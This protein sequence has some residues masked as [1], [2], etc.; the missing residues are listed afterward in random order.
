MMIATLLLISTAAKALALKGVATMV[1]AQS[2]AS[3]GGALPP[4][5][6]LGIEN[7]RVIIDMVQNNPGDPS[8]WEDSKY[9]KPTVLHELGYT[10]SSTTG[11][12]SGTQAVDFSST[13][14]NFFPRGSPQRAWL[15]SYSRGVKRWIARTQAAGLKVY[16]YV[17]LLVFPT[18][19]IDAYP[20][21]TNG[22]GK[23]VWNAASHELLRV[24]V[25]ETFAKFPECDGWIVRTGETYVYDTPY[26]KGNSP[27]DNTQETWASFITALRDMVCEKHQRK[28]FFRSWTNW[29]S[30]QSYYLTLTD[31]IEPHPLLYFS[32]KHSPSD[33]YRPAGWNEQIG[34]GKHAQIIEVQLQ[35]EY[36]GKGS[37][38][39]YIM[40]GV[41]D[42]FPEMTV[43]HGLAHVVGLPQV[44]GLWTWTRGGGW[45]GP[46]IHGREQWIDLHAQVLLGWWR[47]GGRRSEAEV[48]SEVTPRFL[49]GCDST[50]CVQAFREFA[51]SS[52]QVVL[53]GQWGTVS[54]CG[55]W[56]RDD[57]IGG[58]HQAAR[59]FEA[60]GADQRR[61][62]AS[63]AEKSWARDES[64]R[65][66]LLYRNE[67]FPHLQ[68]NKLRDAI[69][70][71]TLYGSHLYSIV[72][73]GW[74]LIAE[75][76]RQKHNMPPLLSPECLRAAVEAYD[77]A[78]AA[79]R[80]FGLSEPMAASLYHP[81]H[82]CLGTTCNNAFE[83]PETDMQ[84]GSWNG[85]NSQGMGHAVDGLRIQALQSEGQCQ[86]EVPGTASLLEDGLGDKR[87]AAKPGALQPQVVEQA[88][89]YIRLPSGCPNR[90]EFTA[91]SWKR[92]PAV[93]SKEHCEGMRKR[94]FGN[95]CGVDD[96]EA[97]FVPNSPEHVVTYAQ[98][99]FVANSSAVC[100]AWPGDTMYG[101][102]GDQD[103]ATWVLLSHE[104]DKTTCAH[105]C[106]ER[107]AE[108]R[109][110]VCCYV[111][112][113][114]HCWMR[115][116]SESFNFGK[117]AGRSTTC[118]HRA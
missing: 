23:V 64:Q 70:V 3:A 87:V 55:S 106:A 86:D 44:R 65:M 63:V 30:R 46:Y 48:F 5:E 62:R 8:G 41:I 16:F 7:E 74:K 80:A 77:G 9:T 22:D 97:F 15:D 114:A 98:K 35:R 79:Y 27:S 110:T 28:L 68:D 107:T 57:R 13:G 54:S 42:G 11:E 104:D 90:P 92:D 60:L 76:Y 112:P 88:G 6:V 95:W 18:F 83:P 1:S 24:L 96:V 21:I 38:P 82:L 113:T 4:T 85:K 39:N 53:H 111:S 99:N 43:K 102:S 118:R 100:E 17:D 56:M 31:R 26:H 51:L 59:C 78:F 25:D 81:Y 84:E 93:T 34:V 73:A 116:N 50:S 47:Y 33:F 67:I 37:Y 89:C 20:N 115:P 103:S 45:W 69:E 105:A 14:R 66:L 12:M 94:T 91:A 72:A 101:C 58:D 29:P 32:I 108:L 40:S 49:K 2:S 36:E 109:T 10:G 71:S 19:V 75:T 117:G 61:W 52:A